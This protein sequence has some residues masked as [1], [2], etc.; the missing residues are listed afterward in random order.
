MS[1]VRVEG[2][3]AGPAVGNDACLVGECFRP[4]LKAAEWTR[5]TNAV[6]DDRWRLSKVLAYR[7]PVGWVLH[8]LLAEDSAANSPDFYLWMVRMPLVIPTDVIDLSWSERFGDSSQVFAPTAPATQEAIAQAAK[9]VSDQAE[10]DESVVDPPGGADNVRMQEARGYGLLLR[11]NTGGAIEVLG[12]V[13]R[14][15]PRYPWEEELVRRAADMR[16]LIESG[17]T[18]EAADRLDAWRSDTLSA[19]G[20][21]AS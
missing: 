20:I 1:V 13:M 11:G 8:G 14:Y 10:S 5:L 2:G 6:L 9:V 4:M 7:V 15:G 18:A 17:Q 21:D 12:R 16:S 19:L 3:T